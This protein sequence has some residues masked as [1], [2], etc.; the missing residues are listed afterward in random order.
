VPFSASVVA[1]EG[2][3]SDAPL[4]ASGPAATRP[5]RSTTSS[6]SGSIPDWSRSRATEAPDSGTPATRV[7]ITLPPFLI[8][9]R[10]PVAIICAG[11]TANDGVSSLMPLVPA[12]RRRCSARSPR[13]SACWSV[14]S[15]ASSF[16]RRCALASCPL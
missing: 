14:R 15:V 7:P 10:E 12:T 16:A 5:L 2:A 9:T 4:S 13:S 8:R 11:P 6:S 1:C 3:V